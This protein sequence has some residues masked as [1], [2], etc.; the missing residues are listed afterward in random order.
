MKRKKSFKQFLTHYR[1]L[2]TFLEDK[3]YASGYNYFEN[4]YVSTMI[5]TIETE[6]PQ[7]RILH[8]ASNQ[9]PEVRHIIFWLR[10]GMSMG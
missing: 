2:F 7:K 6:L 1:E 10:T 4:P 3:D 9:Y 5:G 8:H